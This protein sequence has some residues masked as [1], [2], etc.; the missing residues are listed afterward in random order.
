MKHPPLRPL[1]VLKIISF[2][3]ENPGVADS[4]YGWVKWGERKRQMTEHNQ[5]DG[6][7]E[8]KQVHLVTPKKNRKNSFAKVSIWQ[9]LIT[10][11]VFL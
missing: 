3:I 11:N 9:I 8:K 5:D 6:G 4:D 2:R 10:G 1:K 7:D